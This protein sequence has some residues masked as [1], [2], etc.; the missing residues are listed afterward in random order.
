MQNSLREIVVENIAF[1]FQTGWKSSIT[2]HSTWKFSIFASINYRYYFFNLLVMIT[3]D[4]R[5]VFAG[6][7]CG[8]S[9]PFDLMNHWNVTNFRYKSIGF[10][11]TGS[12]LQGVEEHGSAVN[13]GKRISV[14]F[15]GKL[16]YFNWHKFI[17]KVLGIWHTVTLP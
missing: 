2:N 4:Q 16:I 13:A 9:V 11:S 10:S 15:P 7:K 6:I 12:L 3:E 17:Y 14:R 5:G 8:K 1:V